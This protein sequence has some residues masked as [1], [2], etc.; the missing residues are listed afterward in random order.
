MGYAHIIT[1]N[2]A[3]GHQRLAQFCIVNFAKTGGYMKP[4]IYVLASIVI[5]GSG[6][7]VA[8]KEFRK[9]NYDEAI[10]ICV[11]RLID[12]PDKSEYIIL[13]EDAFYRANTE[14]LDAIKA[15]HTEGRPDRW[16]SV[17]HIYEG[18][19]N[20]QQKIAPLMP[21]YVGAE[22][23][24]AEF[25]FVDAIG[26][27]NNAK[28]NAAAYWYAA[29]SEK[30]ATGDMYKAR[31]AYYLLSN[32]YR[33]YATYKNV[34]DLINEAKQNGTAD[35]LF[36]ITDR[37]SGN[38]NYA[39]QQEIDGFAVQEEN[40]TWYRLH[41]A[42]PAD[43]ADYTVEL[44]VRQVE[45]F[46]DRVSTNR[47]QES[48]EIVDGYEYVYD[49]EGNKVLDS[50]GNPVK[51]PD[52]KTVT[53]FVTETWQEKVATVSGEILYKDRNGSVLRSIPVKSDAVFQNYYAVATGF[54][55]ALTPQS[56]QKIGGQPVPFPP[57]DVLLV[58]AVKQLKCN[59]D[60]VLH[61]YNEQYL[62]R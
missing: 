41:N 1:Q 35:A 4:L 13:M 11:K 60:A 26:E 46:Q 14:D 18:I 32:I 20:R 10:D 61:D 12:N 59:V 51:V 57:D 24:D 36:M 9:G 16:E 42:F 31:E 53:A 44:V 5:L 38:Y 54:Y 55:E 6:C 27:L 28:K 3:F 49:A 7:K 30:L 56:K 48:K 25:K 19:Y 15:L 21:L 52:Y 34:D 22:E 2:I 39:V 29:G 62:G 40:G 17:Y 37:S 45:A 50:L 47:Y 58:D 43:E 23:R 8:E 33:F